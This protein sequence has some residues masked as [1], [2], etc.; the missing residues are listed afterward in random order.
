MRDTISLRDS[1]SMRKTLLIRRLCLFGAVVVAAWL[2]WCWLFPTKVGYDLGWYQCTGAVFTPDSRYVIASGH[3][4][5]SLIDVARRQL[6]DR[7]PEE[8]NKLGI[9]LFEV[10]AVSPDSR[11]VASAGAWKSV[12]LWD[13]QTG[14]VVR[15]FEVDDTAVN[16]LAFTPDSKRLAAGT[17]FRRSR[18]GTKWA[19]ATYDIWLWDLTKDGDNKVSCH[20]HDAPVSGIVFLPDGKRIVS[21]SGD[22]TMRMWDVDTRRQVKQQ[23]E[24]IVQS[25]SMTRRTADERFLTL[26]IHASG[27]G[28]LTLSRDGRYVM[29]TSIVWDVEKW[30]QA[31]WWRHDVRRPG[32]NDPLFS[33]PCALTPDNKRLV[34]GGVDPHNGRAGMLS[35]ISMATGKI[36]FTDHVFTNFFWTHVGGVSLVAVSPDGRYAVAAGSGGSGQLFVPADPHQLYVYRLPR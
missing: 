29:R 13:F 12:R 10:V 4:R 31:T 2:A 28:R 16:S 33:G 20:G 22:Q 9:E 25:A 27:G 5:I 18:D 8:E 34:V 30:D 35:V 6:I 14:R 15:T 24:S 1:A 21:V 3:S 23:G 26:F 32:V 11:F 7:F 17:G 19:Q 36:L